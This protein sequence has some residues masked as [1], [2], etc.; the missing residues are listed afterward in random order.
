M[1]AFYHSKQIAENK[2]Y[3]KG[4]LFEKLLADYLK[5]LGYKIQ[6][7]TKHSSLEYDIEGEHIPTEQKMVGE[8]KAYEKNISGQILSAFVGKVLPLGLLTKEVK[9]VFLSTSPLTPEAE[10]YFRTIKDYGVTVFSGKQLY[11]SLFDIMKYPNPENLGI[12]LK[13][14]GYIVQ[15]E[16]L[17]T[18]DA[19]CFIC[20]VSGNSDTVAPT[21]MTLFNQNGSIVSDLSYIK[22]IIVGCN[23]FASLI[24][25]TLN[26]KEE[27]PVENRTIN[28]GLIVGSSW[29]DYRL[30]AGPDYFI[31]RDLIIANIVNELSSVG[32][33]SILQIKSRS[34]VGKSSTLSMIAYNLSKAG[35]KIELHDARDI[36]SV[37]DL[38]SVIKRFTNNRDMPQDLR[39]IEECLSRF[40]NSIFPNK[41][42]FMVDQFEST[43]INEEI[44]NLYENIAQLIL[45]FRKNMFMIIARKNDQL[46]T[47]DETKIT[48]NRLNE[49]SHSYV[50]Q[51][52]SISE[53]TQL[54]RKINDTSSIS[55]GGD[56]LSY[57]LEFAQG[58]PW[59]LKRTM[60]HLVK[61]VT[62]YKIPQNELF[63]VGLKLDDLFD[64][65]L[66]GLDEIE[67]EYLFRIASKLPSDFNQLQRS[68]DEDPLLIRVLDKLTQM[69]LLR[70]TGATYDTY[71]DVF[72]E[73]LV[74]KRLPEFK[75]SILYRSYPNRTITSYLSIIDK[76]KLTNKDLEDILG[77]KSGS[78]FNSIREWRNFGLIEKD[79]EFWSIPKKILDIYNKN[80]LG[81]YIRRQLIDNEIVSRFITKVSNSKFQEDR[82]PMFL[83]EQFSFVEATPQT[84]QLYANIMKSWLIGVKILNVDNNGFFNTIIINRDEAISQL[85]NLDSFKIGTRKS[86]NLFLPSVSWQYVSDVISQLIN[87]STPTK[88]EYLKALNDISNMGFIINDKLNIEDKDEVVDKI[89]TILNSEP[90]TNIWNATKKQEPLLPI[91]YEILSIDISEETIKWRLKKLLNW[92]K[93]LGLIQDRRY[94]Y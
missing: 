80:Q 81:E 52:F 38:R 59:L 86:S 58:F 40:G 66:D 37:I 4:I 77:L 25:L 28:N 62:Q 63:A 43:F 87:G 6:I 65:E 82:L 48:L 44:F 54:I 72:K 64:E 67:K 91:M 39:E 29:I 74:Y 20:F 60:A 15:A 16:Y 85:G 5:N 94:K 89:K 84:W 93:G 78:V 51:D 33:T 42:I 26:E 83:K 46:T 31:G 71:N 34:G 55:V 70:M 57:V 56:I 13:N 22:E 2:N 35:F 17:L 61:L 19:G 23:E 88:G 24:P 45:K 49:I 79:G 47:Y 11:Q 68:F 73:Y 12:L 7:R 18:T 90:Y 9:G 50:L 27:N 53:A 92:G 3:Y 10:D 1:F 32:E 30:P 76:Q 14:E 75:Q 69:R 21:Y 36:K 8:A 41:A